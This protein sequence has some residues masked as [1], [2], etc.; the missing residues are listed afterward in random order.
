VCGSGLIKALI[1]INVLL[2]FEAFLRSTSGSCIARMQRRY[3]PN[4]SRPKGSSSVR[5]PD[6]DGP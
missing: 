4:A 5:R 1:F 6:Q 2:I 3:G